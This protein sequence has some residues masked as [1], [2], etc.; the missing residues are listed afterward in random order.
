VAERSGPDDD[1]AQGLPEKQLFETLNAASELKTAPAH[2]RLVPRR[3]RS[4]PGTEGD[5]GRS[6]GGFRRLGRGALQ[7]SNAVLEILDFH[8]AAGEVEGGATG[9]DAAGGR[10]F[11]VSQR[12]WV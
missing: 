5:L 1:N 3:R 9:A 4:V 2:H 12:K 8:G 7:V 11:G 6:R 10:S